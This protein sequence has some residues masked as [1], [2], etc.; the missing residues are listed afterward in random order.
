MVQIVTSNL[1]EVS[2]AMRI[3]I[4]NGVKSEQLCCP[5]S[6]SLPVSEIFLGVY[7]FGGGLYIM[8]Y[9]YCD[10]V[11]MGCTTHSVP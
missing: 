4:F 6:I 2:T 10:G 1:V 8:T 11:I 7:L 9:P 5:N 3:E